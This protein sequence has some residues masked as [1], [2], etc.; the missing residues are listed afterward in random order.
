MKRLL[1]SLLLALAL[2]VALDALFINEDLAVRLLGLAGETGVNTYVHRGILSAVGL[3]L[4]WL[5]S[6]LIDLFVWHFGVERRTGVPA[7]KLLVAVVRVLVFLATLAIVIAYVFETPLTGLVVSSGVVGVVLGFALQKM[8]SD[9]FSGI[10]LN[11]ERPFSVGDWINVDSQSG[12][13][14]EM[15]WRAVRMVR[16]DAVTVV[17]PNSFIAERALLNYTAA[18]GCF[19]SELP[20]SLEYGVQPGDAKRVLLAA[21][22]DTQGVLE[23][24]E[25]DV[26]LHAFGNDGVIYLVRF[27]LRSYADVNVV[28][29]RVAESVS[30][31]MWQAGMG[32]PYPKR[33]VYYTPM[34]P[35]EISRKKDR[36]ALLERV[37]LFEG[38]TPEELAQLAEGVVERRVAAGEAVVKQGEPG[39]SLFIVVDGMLGVS[40]H[41]DNQ[42][43]HRV[44]QLSPGQ[45]FG[46]MSLLSGEPRSATITAITEATLHEV[47]KQTLGPILQQRPHI[48]EA[49][50]RA[51]AMRRSHTEAEV[52]RRSAGAAASPRGMAEELLRRVRQFFSLS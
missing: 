33:D 13:V 29:D 38:L 44:A 42:P 21:V 46:E 49:L 48:A 5:L 30:R 40:V 28:S 1:R 19:R 35:R 2:V 47:T 18:R 12:L 25:P 3:S 17:M 43:E 22:R 11:V 45:F 34:P 7:P 10:A 31:H 9:F 15:N 26:L 20:V 6:L 37:S 39:Q 51:V 50:C 27:Y 41:N 32:V 16:L 14:V 24:P 36:A 52:K 8:I 23:Q 4:A